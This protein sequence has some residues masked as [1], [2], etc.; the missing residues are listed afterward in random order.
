MTYC[1]NCGNEISSEAQACDKCGA[2]IY[3]GPQQSSSILREILLMT[4]V[5]VAF[6][7][8]CGV[9]LRLIVKM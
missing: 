5:A 1:S 4:S 8:I 3:V 2:I 9:M 6:M 7:L